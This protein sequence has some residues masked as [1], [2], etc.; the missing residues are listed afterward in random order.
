MTTRDPKN[1]DQL[2]QAIRRLIE[3]LIA[4]DQ[5]VIGVSQSVTDAQTDL[6]DALKRAFGLKVE[7]RAEP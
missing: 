4:H 5:R 3:M 1:V 6:R 7:E 2:A